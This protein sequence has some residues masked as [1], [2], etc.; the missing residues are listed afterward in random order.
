MVERLPE[1]IGA[2]SLRSFGFS[3]GGS[4]AAKRIWTIPG[5][6]PHTL[7]R[8]INSPIEKQNDPVFIETAPVGWFA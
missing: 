5:I 7:H 3:I 2:K 6:S 4:L 8:Q 1:E